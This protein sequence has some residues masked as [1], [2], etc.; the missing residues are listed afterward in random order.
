MVFTERYH[1][2]RGVCCGSGCRHCPYGHEKVPPE[3]RAG[4]KPPKPYFAALILLFLTLALAV[5]A[6]DKLE[7]FVRNRPFDGP[8]RTVGGELY[9]PLDDLLRSMGCGWEQNETAILVRIGTPGSDPR[10][11][12]SV[13][14]LVEGRL[15]EIGAG[16]YQGRLYCSVSALAKALNAEY[17]VNRTLGT[18]DLYAPV[19]LPTG[20]AETRPVVKAG[21]PGSEVELTRVSFGLTRDRDFPNREI[22]RGYAI[23][24]NRSRTAAVEGVT[25]KVEILDS[26]GN[27]LGRYGDNLGKLG[28]GKQVTYQFPAW[29]NTTGASLKPRVEVYHLR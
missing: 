28:A 18:A 10:L 8:V 11:D 4:L 25:V 24:T 12:T 14:I 26:E 21:E 15:V 20:Q 19:A 23:V 16:L 1:L 9:G 2:R 17:R 7:L 29:P 27:V 13:P 5:R 22:L 3:N 6:Q